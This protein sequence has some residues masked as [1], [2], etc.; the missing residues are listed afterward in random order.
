MIVTAG[1]ANVTVDV[2]FVDDDGGTSP[3][4]PTTG[5]LFS[6]IE[7]GGSASYHR[8]GAARVD[9]T[10]VTVAVAGVHTDGGFIEI[11][12]TNMPGLYRLDV[13]DAAFLTGVDYVTIQL[14][15][16]GG[17]NTLMRP[18]LIDLTDV[19]L[20][21]GVRGGMT[22]LPNAAA[23]DVGGLPI[24][25]AGGLDLD[26]QLAETNEITAARMGAL[27]DWLEAGR[28][29][30]ILDIIAADVVN[31][32]GQ[33]M[34]GTDNALLAASAPTNF[35][36]MSIT[37][38]TGLVDI[39]QAAADKVWATASRTL[40]ALGSSLALEVWHVL[41]SAV[42]TASTMGLKVKT[43]LDAVLSDVEADTQDIQSRLP[44]AL[45]GGA[46]DSDVSAMQA[47]V[48]TAAAVATDAIDADAL[49]GDAATE[50]A[51]AILARDI[52]SGTGA[53]SL[54]ERTVR[55]ALRF[56]RN[57]WSIAGS[58]LT[59][60]EEDDTT[61]A[62]TGTITTDAAADPITGNDPA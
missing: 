22:A 49:A 53:G 27:T 59:V 46:M 58:T 36:D 56:L 44:A 45:V 1:K 11:D 15:E 20:R 34:R 42:V 61:T 25:D 18:L 19:N 6:N 26:T 21:D 54:D 33:A 7:T 38:T 32:D 17:N 39:T 51:D 52:G 16:A 12:A 37:V 13:P 60:T 47:G 29:D 55:A 41:E 24:S 43:N 9:F 48:V 5:L 2:Y 57:K 4:E 28:L 30:A 14:V 62:W 10:L 23:D 8:Q 31:L 3:G 50:I 40:T 35:S